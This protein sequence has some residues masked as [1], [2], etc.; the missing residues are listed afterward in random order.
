MNA[1]CIVLVVGK[2]CDF[3]MVGR[4]IPTTD[5][6]TIGGLQVIA[7]LGAYHPRFGNDVLRQVK[8]QVAHQREYPADIAFVDVN[9]LEAHIRGDTCGAPWMASCTPR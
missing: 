9:L 6:S 7:I 3:A 8:L 4:V 2:R 5:K 1:A